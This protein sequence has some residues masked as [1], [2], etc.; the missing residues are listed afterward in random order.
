MKQLHAW[1]TGLLCLYAS[2]CVAQEMSSAQRGKRLYRGEAMLD[3]TP[4]MQGVAL[5]AGGISCAGCHGLSGQ[6]GQEGGTA[7]P[8][9]SAQALLLPRAGSKAYDTVHEA[10]QGLARSEGRMHGPQRRKL[11][12]G[13]PQYQLTA[14]EI[15]DLRAYLDVIGK[16]QDAVPGVSEKSILVGTLLPRAGAMQLAGQELEAGLR[17]QLNAVNAHGGIYGRSLEL[18]VQPLGDDS[19]TTYRDAIATLAQSNVYAV[20]GAWQPPYETATSNA[21]PMVASIGFA[22]TQAQARA[23]RFLLPSLQDQIN[24]LERHMQSECGFASEPIAVMHNGH[25]SV[26]QALAHT[27]FS[28][29]DKVS[30]VNATMQALASDKKNQ[31][32]RRVMS[33]GVSRAS[34]QMID[35]VACW[36]ELAALSGL[37]NEHALPGRKHLTLLPVPPSLTRTGDE[38]YWTRMGRIAAQL[39]VDALSRAG[40]RLD[41]QSLQR[42]F[43]SV[44]QFQLAADIT[45]GYTKKVIPGLSSTLMTSGGSHVSSSN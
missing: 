19:L 16:A 4:T 23:Q 28:T 29:L 3:Q 5:T 30:M 1:A 24:A 10:L 14:Q 43:D 41:E 31:L 42:V 36:A 38:P 44:D 22:S 34:L 37:P 11:A 13:M 12:I 25:A 8:P 26:T 2:C 32:L 21:I 27:S 7:T 40:R 17:N 9:I 33:L 6:G 15:Q 39:L 45:L 20:V 18:V 35:P